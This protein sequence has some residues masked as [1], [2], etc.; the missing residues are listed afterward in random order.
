[1]NIIVG[2]DG[3]HEFDTIQAALD[4]IDKRSCKIDEEVVINIKAGIYEEKLII[5]IPNVT[6][7]GEDAENTVITYGDYAK[8]SMPDGT[9]YGTFRTAT[10][11]I[12]ADNFTA[13]N[14]TFVNSAGDG[15]IHGQAVAVYADGDKISFY[16]CRM[17]ACQDTL[18]TA[19]LPP[20]K[21]GTGSNGNGPKADCERRNGRQY[22]YGCY[23]RGDIDFIFGGAIVFFEECEI[24]SQYGVIEDEAKIPEKGPDDIICGYVTAACTI[25]GE[26]YGYVF[27]KCNFT[28][29]CPK[30]SIYLGRPWRDFAKTVLIECKLGEHIK[31]DGWHDWEKVKA[32][33]TAYY[34]EYKSICSENN[35]NLA[36]RTEW[37]Y[38]INDEEAKKYQRDVV[39]SGWDI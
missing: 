26:E 14:I 11:R 7:I 35:S 32:R 30:N 23:I 37:S 29:D 4:S 15:K 27:Y 19:P 28:S 2:K 10:F 21:A 9:L 13:K 18:F 3:K 5:S 24:F 38:Q 8:M 25:E 16:N 34:A 6:L 31:P 33:D 39:L 20:K 12:D 1:M 22:Y 36:E 17:I